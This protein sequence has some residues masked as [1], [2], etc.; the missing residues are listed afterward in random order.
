MITQK[1][2]SQTVLFKCKKIYSTPTKNSAFIWPIIKSLMNAEF[3]GQKNK[4]A[5]GNRTRDLRTT[6]A[7]HYRLCYNSI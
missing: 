2:L 7:T 4:A 5:D 6:N 1:G 3:I